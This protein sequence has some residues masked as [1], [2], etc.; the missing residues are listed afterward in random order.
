MGL[1]IITL[2]TCTIFEVVLGVIILIQH[3]ALDLTKKYI[4]NFVPFVVCNSYYVIVR[5]THL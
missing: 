5:N 3:N 4:Y 1:E 2:F